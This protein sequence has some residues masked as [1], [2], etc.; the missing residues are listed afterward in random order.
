MFGSWY[1]LWNPSSFLYAGYHPP[2]PKPAF[3]TNLFI[4]QVSPRIPTRR[5]E[6]PTHTLLRVHMCAHVCACV[7]LSGRS[8]D[9]AEFQ[10]WWD[11]PRVVHNVTL[12]YDLFCP[13]HDVSR[14]IVDTI[15]LHSM[16]LPSP[17]MLP[18][19]MMFSRSFWRSW[20]SRPKKWSCVRKWRNQLIRNVSILETSCWQGKAAN[21]TKKNQEI[22]FHGNQPLAFFYLFLAPFSYWFSLL[23]INPIK[24]QLETLLPKAEIPHLFLVSLS[25][26][27]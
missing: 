2:L 17:F 8:A 27:F 1:H 14:N 24:R 3:S 21:L 13:V 20:R 23:K 11:A 10:P 12:A 5:C 26:A 9:A 15:I 19:K 25:K 22:D 7:V 16:H 6:A 4:N 18:W